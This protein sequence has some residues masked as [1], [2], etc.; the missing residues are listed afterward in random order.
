MISMDQTTTPKTKS[1]PNLVRKEA[2]AALLALASL[3]IISAICDAPVSGPVD[4]AGIPSTDVKAPWIFIGIQQTLR[5]FPPLLA[6]IILP[7][8]AILAIA[9]IPFVH[10]KQRKSAWLVFYSIVLA[11][12]VLTLWGY[13]S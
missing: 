5:Y 12:V 6:G 3:A 7:F 8:V 2:L 9:L 13:F 11:S 10:G 1:F 4:P